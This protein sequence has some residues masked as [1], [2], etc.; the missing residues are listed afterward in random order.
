MKA[1]YLILALK[2]SPRMKLKARRFFAAILSSSF[3]ATHAVLAQESGLSPEAQSLVNFHSMSCGQQSELLSETIDLRNEA[4][5]LREYILSSEGLLVQ[6]LELVGTKDFA[7]V[8][9]VD[10]PCD[11][12]YYDEHCGSAG[13]SGYLVFPNGIIAEFLAHSVKSV[14]GE[15]ALDLPGSSILVFAQSP[16]SCR[17]VGGTN[18]RNSRPCA[19]F[20]IWN[21]E[22]VEL[23]GALTRRIQTV[24]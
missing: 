4:A 14:S 16:S 12:A 19:T 18:A 1:N 10:R 11:P 24:P 2:G 22:A 20:A 7:E 5:A 21:G 23:G 6:K 17:Y 9:F 13:C 3:L 8:I 15:E